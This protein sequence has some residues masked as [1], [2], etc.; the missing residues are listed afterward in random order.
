MLW[1]HNY[2]Y[3]HKECQSKRDKVDFI[4]IDFDDNVCE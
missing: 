3:V 1:S 4:H 2:Y